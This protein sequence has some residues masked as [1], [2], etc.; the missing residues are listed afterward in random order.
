[1]GTV[2]GSSTSDPRC[3]FRQ[4]N[5]AGARGDPE[6]ANND[7]KLLSP[8]SDIPCWLWKDAVALKQN[9]APPFP[10]IPD[11]MWEIFDGCVMILVFI[12]CCSAIF[13]HGHGG[14]MFGSL[15]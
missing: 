12:C 3:A 11:L 1:M 8:G 4:G 2:N 15:R 5:G 7:V 9:A 6:T 10:G 14:M 13:G